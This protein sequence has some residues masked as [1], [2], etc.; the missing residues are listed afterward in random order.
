MSVV[1]ENSFP[2]LVAD[3][4][5]SN[6][7]F[8]WIDAPG[9]SVSHV[10][11]LPV[12]DHAGPAE[13]ALTYLQ[14]VAGTLSAGY[15]RPRRAAFAVA[16]PVEGD[17]IVFTNS[18]WDFSTAD[19]Q[20]ALGLDALRMLNDFEALALSLPHLQPAQIRTHGAAPH[21]GGTLAVVGPGT[22][23]GVA[24]VIRS[25]SGW[26]ALPGEGGHVTLAPC[27]DFESALLASVRRQKSHVSAERLLSGIGLPVLHGAVCE[28][29]GVPVVTLTAE[30][31]VEQGLVSPDSACDKTLDVFCAMLG[32]FAGNVAL[33]LGARGGVYIGGGIVPRM[34]D[35]FFAS[36]FRSCFEAKGR[37]KL[38]MQAIPTALITDTLVALT[39]A[40]SAI[41]QDRP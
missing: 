20:A 16:T 1:G 25:A 39:G 5:G 40:A 13:A 12:A 27:D 18:H 22:G 10:Q 21:A 8:G 2:R 29:R 33:T 14:Q 11:R 30:Q 28:V 36:R 23:L 19:V 38:Y 26:I 37:F 6:A 17:R 7:R 4:G 32:S 9:A 34:A 15:R 41:E 31:I 3:I 35:Y 24:G